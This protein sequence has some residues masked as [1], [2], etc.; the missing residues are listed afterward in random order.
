MSEPTPEAQPVHQDVREDPGEEPREE[1]KE[2]PRE[3]GEEAQHGPEEAAEEAAEE[4]EDGPRP[5]G[6]PLEP[7]GHQP[8]DARL[9]RL[10]DAD[11][12]GVA[13]HLEVYE[14]VHRGLRDTLGALDRADAAPA[15][16][17][18]PSHDRS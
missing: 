6:V 4:V 7:T 12:I 16:P 17:P 9:R 10:Q 5:L 2:E 8:V 3:D 1:P 15:T 11:G 14:E 13:G 18:A